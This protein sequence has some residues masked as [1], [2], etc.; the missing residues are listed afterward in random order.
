V[1]P[2]LKTS[3]L[4]LQKDGGGSYSGS[5]K[6]VAA[7]PTRACALDDAGTLACCG[8]R[9]PAT[10]PAAPL[11]AVA[12]GVIDTDCIALNPQTIEPD[13]AALVLAALRRALGE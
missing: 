7:G 12:V 11:S 9:P 3:T 6:T 4:T 1:R 8:D 10:P 2:D 5:F 13:E